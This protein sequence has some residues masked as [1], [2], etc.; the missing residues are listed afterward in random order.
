MP[1]R[2]QPGSPP[3][4]ATRAAPAA[5]LHTAVVAAREDASPRR[6]LALLAVAA[7]AALWTARLAV[8]QADD[9][10]IV[11]RYATNLANGLGFVFNPGKR[12]E[13][14][15]C[16][17]WTLLLVPFAAIRQSLLPLP[18]VARTLTAVAGVA[19]LLVLPSIGAR[20][21]RR[22]RWR[23][24]DLLA[25]LL[26]GSHPAFAY[27]SAGALETVP[28]AL[29]LCLALRAYLRERDSLD[30]LGGWRSAVLLGAATMVRPEAPVAIAA[31]LAD[32]CWRAGSD[33]VRWRAA[34]RWLLSI[35]AV[36]GPFLLFRRSY[37]GE[38]L[39]NTYYAKTGWGVREQAAA[40]A[41]YSWNFL[42]AS[43]PGP[44][45]LTAPLAAAALL[46]L[47]VWGLRR[48]RVRVLAL[49][50]SAS[51][52]AV[53]FEGADWMPLF[54]FFVPMLPFVALLAQS[55]AQHLETTM[56]RRLAVAAVAAMLVAHHVAWGV[57]ER[58]GGRGLLA[59]EAGYDRAHR[60]V[61]RFLTRHARP[62][63]E[64]ALMDVGI[65]GYETG[66]RVFDLSG[67][68]EPVVAHA[69]G[70]FLTKDYPPAVV[71]RRAPA[72]VVLVLSDDHFPIDERI[73]ASPELRRDYVP[74]MARNHRQ[75]WRPPGRYVLAVF[76]RRR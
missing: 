75:A 47:L 38:W 58:N 55:F 9:A 12:V 65:V 51:I 67:L 76:A 32:R 69:P 29:L 46:G 7:L 71:F 13:G 33:R 54:R 22:E 37:F 2:T 73:A 19:L 34:A 41:R 49:L 40:G 24:R 6:R 66:L 3:E 42:A 15:S 63:D 60:E 43:L 20:L 45:A 16:F 10:Y 44:P 17:L 59:N 61:A 56:V 23:P 14:V 18:M 53:L 5:D 4:P 62:G 11:Y 70:G 68:T 72:F 21:D 48:E 52:A 74:V 50:V 30:T 25:P 36:A 39:P 1:W 35:A 26:L 64:V 31:L 28:Y 8:Y 27:W 57:A